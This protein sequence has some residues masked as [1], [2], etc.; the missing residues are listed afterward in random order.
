MRRS[1]RAG[2]V[3]AKGLEP[4]HLSIPGPKPGASTSS[5]TPAEAGKGGVYSSADMKGKRSRRTLSGDCLKGTGSG[6]L[7]QVALA[8]AGTEQADAD[9]HLL[10][11]RQGGAAEAAFGRKATDIPVRAAA[12]G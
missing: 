9:R 4:P 10:D 11:Q 7:R 5:A 12:A 1:L 6:G 8:A 3:R 2:L